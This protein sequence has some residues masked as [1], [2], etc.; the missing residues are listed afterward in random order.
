METIIENFQASKL[1]AIRELAEQQELVTSKDLLE[2]IERDF[3]KVHIERTPFEALYE[4][5]KS[6]QT[7]IDK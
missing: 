2:V 7:P 4:Y 3:E 6:L 5:N 1:E